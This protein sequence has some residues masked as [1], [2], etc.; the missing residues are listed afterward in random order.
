MR[1]F[2]FIAFCL[3][4]FQSF[5]QISFSARHSAWAKGHDK[6]VLE[7]F[8]NTETIFAL[9]D[10]Y[11]KEAYQKILEEAWTVTPFRIVNIRDFDMEDYLSDK[12]SIVHLT[13]ARLVWDGMPFFQCYIDIKMHK[14]EKVIKKL[15][16]FS[17]KK[18]PKNEKERKERAQERIKIFDKEDI[19]IARFVLFCKANLVADANNY[20]KND[21]EEIFERM[22]S[23]DLFFN[24][25][26]GFLKN[27]FQ[28]INDLIIKEKKY[29]LFNEDHMPEIKE[30]ASQT[31][32][33]PSYLS[34]KYISKKDG[35]EDEMY[36][37]ELFKDY[38][39]NYK[40]VSNEELSSRIM[41]NEEFYYIRYV[42]KMNEKFLQVI[43]A[44]NGEIIY[45]NYSPSISKNIKGK[46][47][48]HL[49]KTIKEA[50]E[51]EE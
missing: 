27:Y 31:L 20:S 49:S 30:L 35:E 13:G 11:E 43:K 41:N 18:K 9:S 23:E 39:Y 5:S 3:I 14:N 12:Y 29:W 1:N 15:D 46:Y 34:R 26:P 22:I 47:F 32:Y 10:I 19:K 2:I 7:R 44:A 8:K 6:A 48:K 40:V 33:V 42:R 36:I 38:E 51:K 28:K 50:L 37:K 21:S 17:K 24:Y 25:N 4:S 16:K 45:S